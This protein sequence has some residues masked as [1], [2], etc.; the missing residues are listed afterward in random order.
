MQSEDL[1]FAIDKLEHFVAV[2]VAVL[3][4][5]LIAVRI[6]RLTPFRV[7]FALSCGLGLGIVKEIGDWAG[8]RCLLVTC[9]LPMQFSDS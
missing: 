1:W 7:T 8:V 5:Y 9:P 6:E 2:A 3:V 4:A